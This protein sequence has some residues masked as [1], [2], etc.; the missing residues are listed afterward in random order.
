MNGIDSSFNV[1][2]FKL[3]MT[4][5]EFIL[6]FPGGSG[7]ELKFHFLSFIR[8]PQHNALIYTRRNVNENL[9][10]VLKSACNFNPIGNMNLSRSSLV[11]KGFPNDEN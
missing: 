2:I 10:Q 8:Y 7:L 1:L 9:G 11:L 3:F 6:F 4:R 5:E